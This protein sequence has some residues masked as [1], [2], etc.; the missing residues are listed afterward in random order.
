MALTA[1]TAMFL[2]CAAPL[3]LL[4]PSPPLAA[5][6]EERH[7]WTK[8]SGSHLESGWPSQISV[9]FV[10]DSSKHT[11]AEQPF[12]TRSVLTL[13]GIQVGEWVEEGTR[14]NS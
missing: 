2:Q 3:V 10:R 9:F 8:P 1:A 14:L 6:W 4:S 5:V 13:T 7:E 12:I 11:S